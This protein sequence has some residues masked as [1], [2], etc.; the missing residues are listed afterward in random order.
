MLYIHFDLLPVPAAVAAPFHRVLLAQIFRPDLLLA[1]LRLSCSQ[2][3][4]VSPEAATQPTVQQ[5]LEQSSCERPILMISQPELDPATELRG[6]ALKKWGAQ[7]YQELAIGRGSEQRALQAMRQAA[8]LGQWL[9]VK[10]VHLVPEWLAQMERELAEMPKSQEFRLWLLCESTRGFSEAAVYKCLKV[11][12]EQPRGLKQQVQRMLQNYAG[13]EPELASKQPAKCLKMRLVL[14]LLQA[15]LQQRRQYIPQGWSKYYEFGEADLKAALGVLGWLDAQLASGRCDWL[16][17]QRLSE[18]LAYGGRMNNARDV[19][20]LRSYLAQFLCADVLSNRW[21]PLGLGN[22]LPTSAQLQDYYAA[23]E[24]LPEVD[25]PRMY[26]LASQAQQQREIE[27]ARMVI[28]DLRAVHY[29]GGAGVTAAGAGG[30]GGAVATNARQRLEQQIKPLLSLWRKLAASCNITQVAKEAAA[31]PA[32][33]ATTGPWALFVLAE[34]QLGAQ[35]YRAVHQ[36]LSQLHAW[37]KETT[38]SPTNVDASALQALAE[39][40]VGRGGERRRT[41]ETNTRL[42]Y[43][44]PAAG[45]NYGP[46][47]AATMLWI[48]Y[49]HLWCGLRPPSSATRSKCSWNSHR[50]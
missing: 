3:L 8:S 26:G 11:R 5:L 27:Q 43:R 33:T 36:L 47:R 45:R 49:V 18:A 32:T 2:L 4:G 30:G 16:L 31:M 15:V 13:L 28:R 39:Q 10:N 38:N 12:Y 21:I 23:L 50:N 9:C 1:Q 37:L 42:F 44:C 20:I 22:S 29:G 14:F 41:A 46:V 48:I 6:V 19:E 40:Q 34:L 24:K 7:K 17:L 25:E 35:L